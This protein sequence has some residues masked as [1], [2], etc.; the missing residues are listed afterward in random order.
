[1]RTRVDW[2]LSAAPPP[3]GLDRTRGHETSIPAFVRQGNRKCPGEANARPRLPKQASINK[4]TL[5]FQH[6]AKIIGFI[7]SASVNSSPGQALWTL[8]RNG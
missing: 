4:I 2:P 7:A 1:M 6:L 3:D 5:L 8:H